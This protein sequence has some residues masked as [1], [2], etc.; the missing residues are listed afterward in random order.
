MAKRKWMIGDRIGVGNP[1]RPTAVW[2]IT[3]LPKPG[4]CCGYAVYLDGPETCSIGVEFAIMWPWQNWANDAFLIEDDFTE[5]VKE[6]RSEHS[7]HRP[8]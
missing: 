2:E 1:A 4:E 8:S 6:V 3:R 7:K 5:W